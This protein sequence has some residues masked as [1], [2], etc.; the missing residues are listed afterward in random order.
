[1]T[2]RNY[3][4]VQR[5]IDK[6]REDSGYISQIDADELWRRGYPMPHERA[7]LILSS[8]YQVEQDGADYVCVS[9]ANQVRAV[10][11]YNE[12]GLTATLDECLRID[13]HA[14]D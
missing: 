11:F 9:W 14:L 5:E 10:N 12:Y 7:V 3:A 4:K 13:P 8:C 6:R 1:M 2:K